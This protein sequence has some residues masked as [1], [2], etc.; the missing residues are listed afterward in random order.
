MTPLNTLVEQKFLERGSYIESIVE[1]SE[2]LNTDIEDIVENLS[3]ILV[4]KIKQEFIDKNYFPELK[5]TNLKDFFK[6]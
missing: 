1:I 6:K 3:P 4:A 5:R 2:D